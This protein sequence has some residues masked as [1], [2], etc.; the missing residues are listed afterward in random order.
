MRIFLTGGTG[1]IGSHLLNCLLKNNE[2][3]T[4]LKRNEK[5]K[6]KILL[7]KEP[8]WVINSLGNLNNDNL[9]HQDLLVHLA[10]HSAQP[11][12]DNLQNC[13]EKNVIEP[14]ALFEKAYQSGVRR[15]LVAGSCFEYGLSAN[16]YEFIPPN[17]PLYPVDTYPSSKALASIAFI[18][19]A[20]QK[21]VSLSIQRLFYVFGEGEKKDRFY[22]SIKK[23]AKNGFDFEMTK[24]EQIRD[25]AEVNLIAKIIHNECTRIVKTNKYDIRIKNIGSG[26]NL[27]LRDFATKIWERHNAKGKLKIGSLPY[28]EKEIM[29]FVPDLNTINVVQSFE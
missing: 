15:F 2:D 16:N 22:P 23:A 25:I 12:Y 8:N 10:A 20:I 17:A 5:S 1:F 26:N 7:N 9:S 19:W 18:Q 29:R 6:T 27:S 21:K 11:P 14:L 24:G 3:I 13:I 4:A 28:R